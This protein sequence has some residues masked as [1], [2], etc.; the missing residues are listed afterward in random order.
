MDYRQ[1]QNP[2]EFHDQLGFCLSNYGMGLNGMFQGFYGPEMGNQ[3]FRH[4]IEQIQLLMS[5]GYFMGQ[6]GSMRQ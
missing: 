4:Q 2:T 6:R 3:E 1:L 5:S